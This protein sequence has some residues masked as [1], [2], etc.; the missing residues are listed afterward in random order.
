M[1]L[2]GVSDTVSDADGKCACVCMRG[3]ALFQLA[4]NFPKNPPP[5]A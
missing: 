3:V 5:S 4:D 2:W 1:L